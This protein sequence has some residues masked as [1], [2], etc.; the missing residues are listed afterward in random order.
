LDKKTEDLTVCG[1][2]KSHHL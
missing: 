1:F 2:S